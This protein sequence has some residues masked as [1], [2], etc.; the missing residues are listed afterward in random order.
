MKASSSSPTSILTLTANHRPGHLLIIIQDTLPPTSASAPTWPSSRWD[1]SS[2]TRESTQAMPTRISSLPIPTLPKGLILH[3]DAATLGQTLQDGDEFTGSCTTLRAGNHADTTATPSKATAS[4]AS[5]CRGG[6][7]HNRRR[8][9]HDLIWTAMV[10]HHYRSIHPHHRRQICNGAQDRLFHN[11]G[12]NGSSDT[13]IAAS[14]GST[15]VHG[16][17]HRLE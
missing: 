3:L 15:R 7:E 17:Q 10:P 8:W 16:C 1:K 4:M 2:K 6:W 11:D 12:R 14:G 5:R 9:Q 13:M